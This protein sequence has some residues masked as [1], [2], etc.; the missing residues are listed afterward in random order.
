MSLKNSKIYSK[1]MKDFSRK[2]LPIILQIE[3]KNRINKLMRT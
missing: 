3:A 2:G 1:S